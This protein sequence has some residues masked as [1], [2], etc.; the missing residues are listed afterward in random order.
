MHEKV[1]VL[2]TAYNHELFISEAIESVI[3]QKTK[4]LFKLYI[5]DDC[6]NDKTEKIAETYAEKYPDYICYHHNNYNRGLL[7]NYLYLINESDSEYICILESDDFWID[8]LKIEKE[9]S[10]LEKNPSYG[11]VA[12][13]YVRVNDKSIEFEYMHNL[14]DEK[15]KGQWYSSLLLRNRICPAT[16]CFRRSIMQKYCNF[17]DYINLSFA[18]F[19]YPVFLTI[20]AN[21]LCG[22]IQEKS[23][24][25]RVLDNSIS[26]TSDYVKSIQFEDSVSDIQEYIIHLFG[27]GN[28][29][30]SR[31]VQERIRRYIE[32]SLKFSKLKSFVHYSG[33]LECKTKKDICIKYLPVLFYIIHKIHFFLMTRTN[34]REL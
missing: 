17:S 7:K 8:P 10:Y 16:V 22:Y 30:Y 18:T 34:K 11:L 20:A 32:K 26:N 3:S 13:D 2:M 1:A 6:S 14:F 25:Y 23:A 21:S 19:D 28:T 9:V 31:I 24:S 33:K 12:S 4:Y 29:D 15:L 5:S 27:T